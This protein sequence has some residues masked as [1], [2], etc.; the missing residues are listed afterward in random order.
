MKKNPYLLAASIMFIVGLSITVY[1]VV[2]FFINNYV[3]GSH[4]IVPGSTISYGGIFHKPTATPDGIGSYG[5]VLSIQCVSEDVFHINAILYKFANGA[6]FSSSLDPYFPFEPHG[7]TFIA[8][9]MDVNATY[10]STDLLNVLF[11]KNKTVNYNGSEYEIIPANVSRYSPTA[12]GFPH[13]YTIVLTNS[14]S[15]TNLVQYMRTGDSY[16]ATGI[17]D[18]LNVVADFFYE[19]ITTDPLDICSLTSTNVIP[20]DQDWFYGMSYNFGYLTFPIPLILFIIGL[21][22][23]VMWARRS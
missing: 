19:N 12:Y 18:S 2:G 1:P 6:K 14:E 10:A 3:T 20:S 15:A 13:M 9:E 16:L 23:I 17:Y 11:P 4:E 21:V 8:E 7:S 5:Y 22:L